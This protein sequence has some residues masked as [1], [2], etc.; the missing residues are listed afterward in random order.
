MHSFCSNFII[1]TQNILGNLISH[2]SNNSDPAWFCTCSATLKVLAQKQGQED[3]VDKFSH[4][5]NANESSWGEDAIMT[6][7]VRVNVLN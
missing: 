1:N 2:I 4:I 5:F 6:F 3:Y 7:D